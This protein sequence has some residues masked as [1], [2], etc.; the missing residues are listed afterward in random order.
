MGVWQPFEVSGV[1]ASVT[2]ATLSRLGTDT[3]PM[4][5]EI[6][7]EGAGGYLNISDGHNSINLDPDEWPALKVVIERMLPLC[8]PVP[9][10]ETR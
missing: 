6:V 3:P 2:G 4:V 10:K 5:V 7:D 1:R 8:A 9:P